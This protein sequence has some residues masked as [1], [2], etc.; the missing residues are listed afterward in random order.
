MAV[1][2]RVTYTA[3]YSA[4]AGKNGQAPAN[5]HSHIVQLFISGRNTHG[6]NV[7]KSYG[8]T[9]CDVRAERDNA[10]NLVAAKGVGIERVTCRICTYKFKQAIQP[11]AS[12][13]RGKKQSAADSN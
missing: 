12:T 5:E 1:K 2:A 11:N 13:N 3:A 6:G 10:N 8:M 9:L 4:R 7:W